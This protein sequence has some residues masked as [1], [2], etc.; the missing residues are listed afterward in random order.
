MTTDF[1]ISKGRELAPGGALEVAATISAY[2]HSMRPLKDGEPDLR[3]P[4][5]DALA[6]GLSL[7]AGKVNPSI[8]IEQGNVWRS[9]MLMALSDLPPRVAIAA[10]KDAMHVPMRFLN[11]V[12]AV[13][14]EKAEPIFARHREAIHRLNRLLADIQRPSDNLLGAPA[15]YEKGEVP[16][17]TD[18]EV[19][20]AWTSGLG[21]TFIKLG[22]AMGHISA[23]RVESLVA[24][25]T[26]EGDSA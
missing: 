21:R 8:S 13:I 25:I 3:G 1:S 18:E 9:A 16:D 11:E 7:I 20:K 2:E 5:S 15:G 26:V 6:K 23:E 14:R 12:E 19:I 24:G 4:A 10:A 17:L 22:I